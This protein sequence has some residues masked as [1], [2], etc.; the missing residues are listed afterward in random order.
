VELGDFLTQIEATSDR[1]IRQI[2]ACIESRS[3]LPA[4]EVAWWRA[5]LTIDKVIRES[6]CS[7]SASLAAASASQTVLT[8]A[9]KADIMLPDADF[10]CVA[11]SAGDI[12][13]AYVAG[14]PA[15]DALE[16][17]LASWRE[18]LTLPAVSVHAA[19]VLTSARRRGPIVAFG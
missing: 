7:R 11:R 6:R 2:S 14:L 3:S 13:R 19:P 5:H 10:T 17:L 4:D 15:L 9:E 16:Y 18:V 12:A 8:V 1:D